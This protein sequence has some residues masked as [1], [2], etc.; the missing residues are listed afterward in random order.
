MNVSS[1]SSG[2][3]LQN[4]KQS[5]LGDSINEMP[6]FANGGGLHFIIFEDVNIR[7]ET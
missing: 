5:K 4:Q 2:D 1:L 3:N 7:Y 6:T